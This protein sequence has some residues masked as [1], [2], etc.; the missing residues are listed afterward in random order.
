MNL[1]NQMRKEINDVCNSLIDE[2]A[3][4]TVIDLLHDEKK[5]LLIYEDFLYTFSKEILD[6]AMLE[7]ET[8]KIVHDEMR[9]SKVSNPFLLLKLVDK[10]PNYY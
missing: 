10:C 1:K 7:V 6:Q 2:L 9:N 5:E 3:V 4:E 8:E